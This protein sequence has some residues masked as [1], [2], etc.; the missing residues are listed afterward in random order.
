MVF[1]TS[2]GVNRAGDKC[3]Q[4]RT[5]NDQFRDLHAPREQNSTSCDDALRRR[6]KPNRGFFW[7]RVPR[8]GFEPAG[9]PTGPIQVG[10]RLVFEQ[11]VALIVGH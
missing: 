6:R 1:K 3:R 10:S 2:Y 8:A 7:L 5:G 11:R 9:R 4:T